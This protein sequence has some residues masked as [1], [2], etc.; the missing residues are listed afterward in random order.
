MSSRP[1]VILALLVASSAAAAL[2][3]DLLSVTPEDPLGAAIDIDAGKTSHHAPIIINGDA[4]LLLG[5]TI[6]KNGVGGGKGTADDPFRLSGWTVS[7]RAQDGIIVLNTRFHLVIS[8]NTI[9]DG[10]DTGGRYRYSGIVLGNAENVT[11]ERNILTRDYH[12]ILLRGDVEATIGSNVIRESEDAGISMFDSTATLEGNTITRAGAYAVEIDSSSPGTSSLIARSNTLREN[13]G[14]V[15][16]NGAMPL[17]ISRNVIEAN[18]GEAV[19]VSETS[20]AR[21]ADNR[22]K[23]NGQGFAL[24]DATGRLKGNDVSRSADGVVLD[25]GSF[26]VEA[27]SI[28][29]NERG[30]TIA[31]G[32]HRIAENDIFDNS[33]AGV[34]GGKH[35]TEFDRNWW[36]TADG[37]SGTGGGHGDRVSGFGEGIPYADEPLTPPGKA[38]G[39]TER[40][41]GYGETTG[42]NPV[43]TAASDIV[44]S[45]FDAAPGLLAATALALGTAMWIDRRRNAVQALRRENVT[46]ASAVSIT[47]GSSNPGTRAGP[48]ESPSGDAS[49][50]E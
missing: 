23:E 31:D 4:E 45:A 27:N 9:I 46:A 13:D 37:P 28:H 41:A 36:G 49:P 22:V 47:S 38:R 24:H 42:N 21:I 20:D 40:S 11:I 26:L 18:L 34:V 14:G 25:G 16:A 8:D 19:S 2:P 1:A 5:D 43:T 3:V 32:S 6:L 10:K 17:D 7:A 30:I 15:K 48:S 44:T 33:D 50:E 35:S 12:G 39:N 29:D